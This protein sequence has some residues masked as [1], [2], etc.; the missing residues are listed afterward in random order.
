[1]NVQKCAKNLV[2]FQDSP[3]GG[4]HAGRQHY[5]EGLNDRRDGWADGR[6]DAWMDGGT[7]RRTD[8]DRWVKR[9]V[10]IITLRHFLS[11]VLAFLFTI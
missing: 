1:M 3:P 10:P 2:Q 7:G 6:A 4:E 11:R 8:E 9:A 5:W